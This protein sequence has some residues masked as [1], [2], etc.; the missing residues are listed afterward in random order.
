MYKYLNT[1]D[2]VFMRTLSFI[3]GIFFIK[4]PVPT[5]RFICEFPTSSSRI[6]RTSC[7]W[8]NHTW[9]YWTSWHIIMKAWSPNHYDCV[10]R[11]L[12]ITGRQFTIYHLGI[13]YMVLPL[14]LAEVQTMPIPHASNNLRELSK[15]TVRL[16]FLQPWLRWSS[17]T[18]A[19]FPK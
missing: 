19:H 7:D 4:Y 10:V 17:T 2:I 8:R 11:M 12:T 6:T 3:L 1:L 18:L 16:Q 15:A 9:W 13:Q 5:T 14:L